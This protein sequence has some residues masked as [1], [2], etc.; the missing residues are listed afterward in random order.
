MNKILTI[1]TLALLMTFPALAREQPQV[2]KEK[3]APL[4]EGFKFD[5]IDGILTKDDKQDNWFFTPENN[6]T[7]GRGLIPA[8]QKIQLLSSS[9]LEAMTAAAEKTPQGVRLSATVT[10]YRGQNF[11]FPTHFLLTSNAEQITAP[12]EKQQEAD[13]TKSEDDSQQ[14]SIIPAD[15]LKKLKPKNQPPLIKSKQIIQADA[16][17][18]LPSRTGFVI[19]DEQGKSFK[20]DALGRNVENINLEL[21]PC[22]TLEKLENKIAKSPY[23]QRYRIVGITT[24]YKSNYYLLPQQAVRTYNHGN[25][26]R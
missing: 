11:L 1:S 5:R 12:E 6:L 9:T 21:L 13:Q 3:P 20:I 18:I 7:D 10:K 19:I 15:V 8:G 23:R 4:I 25:F 2:P 14:D 16:D 26:A 17:S 22:Q 24:K